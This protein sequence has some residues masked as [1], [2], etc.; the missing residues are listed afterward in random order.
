LLSPGNALRS[1]VQNVVGSAVKYSAAGGAVEITAD[2][3][4][5]ADLPQIFKPFFRGRRAVD[6]QVRG[7]GIGLSVVKH[8]VQ[9]HGGDVRVES[10]AGAG[11]TITIVLPIVSSAV[12][13][14][15]TVVR[16]RPG[17]VS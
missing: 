1:V 9:S 17:A 14:R 16:L 2:T 11:T 6:A 10:G 8:V 7:S 12:A 15:A 3:V 13:A 5:A 4:D